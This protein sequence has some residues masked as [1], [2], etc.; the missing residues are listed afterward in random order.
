M[1]LPP[2][3]PNELIGSA[4]IRA[5][6]HTGLPAR[7]LLPRLGV[8][9]L[10]LTTLFL[11]LGLAEVA[12]RSGLNAQ[13][14]LWEH[15]VF[16]YCVAYFASQDVELYEA[17]ALDRASSV[18]QPIVN[19]L[20]H[21][22]AVFRYCYECAVDDVMDLGESYWRRDHCFP[23]VH[24]CLQHDCPLVPATPSGLS[25]Q[26]L[27][28][29][30]LPQ[31][32]SPPLAGSSC[33]TWLRQALALTASKIASGQWLH[34]SDWSQEYRERAIGLGFTHPAGTLESAAMAHTLRAGVGSEYLRELA[35]DFSEPRRSWP[36]LMVRPAV[37]ATFS[38]IKHSILGAFLEQQ[39]PSRDRFSYSKPGKGSRT[40]QDLQAMDEHMSAAVRQKTRVLTASGSRTTLESMMVGL[41]AWQTF[42][43][44]KQSLPL[45]REAVDAFK[46]SDAAKRKTGGSDEYRRRMAEIA[47]GRQKPMQTY[48]ER[49]GVKR[50]DGRELD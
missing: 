32:V 46:S 15:T 14:L 4:L 33:P 39:R 2:L 24:V 49:H 34:R 40:P 9:R 47:A 20:G 18:N 16:P 10:G 13:K 45:T 30:P 38:A 50:I 8:S 26:R 35:L 7:V 29:T 25:C 1:K 41:G 27:L 23:G 48:R 31:R 12:L 6:I 11:P 28:S 43:C 22:G 3:Y 19:L 37:T 21:C 36:T 5:A 42:R 44:Q 17:F